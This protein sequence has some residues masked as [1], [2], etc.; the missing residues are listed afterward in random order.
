MIFT[1]IIY[2]SLSMTRT[3]DMKKYH[4]HDYIVI[5]QK[6]GPDLIS[7]GL[8]KEKKTHCVLEEKIRGMQLSGLKESKHLFCK[9]RT[10]HLARNCELRVVP[11]QQS[12][13]KWGPPSYN[14]KEMNSFNNQQGWKIPPAS[15]ESFSPGQYPDTS[16]LRS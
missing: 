1:C 2:S 11:G 12:E 8:V 3:Y 14:C 13:L 10:E 6:S 5:W 16:L 15:G 7:L 9:L 4:S